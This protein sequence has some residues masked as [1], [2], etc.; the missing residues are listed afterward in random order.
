MSPKPKIERR[1]R[2]LRLPVA[3]DDGLVAE[4]K[5]QDLT[6]QQAMEQAVKLWLAEDEGERQAWRDGTR[7]E[8]GLRTGP[9]HPPGWSGSVDAVVD[10]RRHGEVTPLFGGKVK[11]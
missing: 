9:Q 4:A 5:R 2:A 7:L 11:T 3:L 6:V 8:P 1:A 10:A